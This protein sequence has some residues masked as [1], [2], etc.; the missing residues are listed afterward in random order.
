MIFRN[1]IIFTIG[2]ACLGCA[3]SH[4]IASMAAWA[5]RRTWAWIKHGV[6]DA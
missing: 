4:G 2:P 6:N 1:E 3:S 5:Q